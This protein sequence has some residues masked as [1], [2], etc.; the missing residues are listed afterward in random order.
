MAGQREREREGA[1]ERT[2][3]TRLA[4]GT[5]REKEGEERTRVSAEVGP[6]CQAQGTRGRERARGLG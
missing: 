1:R 2:A 3:P 4:H 6:A 5:E